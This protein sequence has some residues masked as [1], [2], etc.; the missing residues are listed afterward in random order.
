M[1]RL[2]ADVRH[3]GGASGAETRE[4]Q[5]EAEGTGGG[6]DV[7]PVE[8]GKAP[9]DLDRRRLDLDRLIVQLDAEGPLRAPQEARDLLLRDG[10]QVEVHALCLVRVLAVRELFTDNVALGL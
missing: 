5:L 7:V 8:H 9:V 10:P 1:C 4:G 6:D 2:D 3:T